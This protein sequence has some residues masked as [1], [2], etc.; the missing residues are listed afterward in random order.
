MVAVTHEIGFA[1]DVADRIVFMDHGE[2]V[3]TGPTDE[4][5]EN[6]KH[7]R[8]REFLAAVR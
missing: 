3:E 5:F 7:L 4:V 2:I 1:R 6:P 8:T